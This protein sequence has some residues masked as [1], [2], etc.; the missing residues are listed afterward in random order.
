MQRLEVLAARCWRVE[1]SASK[2]RVQ[3]NLVIRSNHCNHVQKDF[4]HIA[5]FNLASGIMSW[6]ESFNVVDSGFNR[7]Q[8]RQFVTYQA[9]CLAVSTES[10]AVKRALSWM[11][12]VLNHSHPFPSVFFGGW[13]DIHW[14]DQGRQ[15]SWWPS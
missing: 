1:H 10:T 11:N 15:T 9:G 2:K 12:F 13:I 5:T 3:K 4:A 14:H 6:V 8:E 7:W